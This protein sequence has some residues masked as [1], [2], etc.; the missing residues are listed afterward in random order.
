MYLFIHLT[1]IYIPGSYMMTL[2]NAA[3]PDV[4]PHHCP[5]IPGPGVASRNQRHRLGQVINPDEI[6][7][8]FNEYPTW[9]VGLELNI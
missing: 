3:S 7:L 5:D 9:T 4:T 6:Q 1:Y 8:S 2:K